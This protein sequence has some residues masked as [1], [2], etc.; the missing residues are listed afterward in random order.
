[1]TGASS[2]GAESRIRSSS[3]RPSA[4]STPPE[5]RCGLVPTGWEC[6]RVGDRGPALA[7]GCID[8]LAE[9]IVA[10]ADDDGDVLVLFGTTLIVWVVTNAGAAVPGYYTVPHTTSGK[11]LVGGPS[12]AG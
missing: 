1:M 12:N 8:A 2:R 5:S 3:R 11:M 7:S 4:W 6:A 10:G 9:Q